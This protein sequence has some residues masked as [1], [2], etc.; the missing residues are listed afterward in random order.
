MIRFNTFNPAII[1]IEID[2]WV[3]DIIKLIYVKK[4]S[5]QH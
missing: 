1:K 4:M 2:I 3:P 5:S